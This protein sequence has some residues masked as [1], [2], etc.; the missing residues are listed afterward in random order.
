MF[1]RSNFVEAIQG[2][3]GLL[4]YLTSGFAQVG[5]L[6][7]H[8]ADELPRSEPRQYDGRISE[9]VRRLS[10]GSRA[11][12]CLSDGVVFHPIDFFGTSNDSL[13]NGDRRDIS[14]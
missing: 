1:S 13:N 6:M 8:R 12:D 7:V 10:N 2:L 9:L 14:Q 3:V 4:R 11:A 5:G